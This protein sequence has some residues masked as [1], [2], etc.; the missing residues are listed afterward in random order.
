MLRLW[1]DTNVA[2]S[3]ARLRTLCDL[4][5]R[6]RV[7][8]AVH[9]QVYLERRRQMRAQTGTSFDEAVFDAFLRRAGIVVPS[10]TLDQPTAA[11]WAD[12]L[13]R[14][15]PTHDAWES[16]KQRTLGGELRAGFAVSP[17]RMPMTTDWLIALSIEPE[18]SWRVI[19]DDKGEEWCALRD[20]DPCRALRW[21]DAVAWLEAL[22][23]APPS[24]PGHGR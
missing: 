7:E 17:G 6:K 12:L 11:A 1:L 19:T 3:P 14:R 4:A 2:F 16:A 24:A 5:R 9:P 23:D 22:P 13:H 15:Y 20:A 18:P 21:D 10:F 8:V